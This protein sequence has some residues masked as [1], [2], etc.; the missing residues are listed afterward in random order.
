LAAF[1]GVRCAAGHGDHLVETA[2]GVPDVDLGAAAAAGALHVH[3]ESAGRV[4][5]GA[6]AADH[7]SL[8]IQAW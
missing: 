7:W 4:V 2:I 3:V 8:T 1:A 5:Q 6:A